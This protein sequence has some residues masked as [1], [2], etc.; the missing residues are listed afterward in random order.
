[1]RWDIYAHDGFFNSIMSSVRFGPTNGQQAAWERLGPRTDK[2]LFITATYDPIIISKDLMEDAE[3]L[4][5]SEN[6]EWVVIDGF[7]NIPTATPDQIVREICG[8]WEI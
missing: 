4:L 6:I 3:E 2:I 7:H 8:H 5:G 1:M